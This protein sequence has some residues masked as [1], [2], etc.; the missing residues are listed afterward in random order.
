MSKTISNAKHLEL[1]NTALVTYAIKTQY[2]LILI[3]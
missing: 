2:G 3:T 1:T